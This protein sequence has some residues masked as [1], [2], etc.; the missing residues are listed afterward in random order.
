M[1]WSRIQQGNLYELPYRVGCEH[2]SIRMDGVGIR[3]FSSY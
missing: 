3:T 2:Q 1:A